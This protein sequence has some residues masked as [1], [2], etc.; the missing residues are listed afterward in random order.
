MSPES[1]IQHMADLESTRFETALIEFSAAV[2]EDPDCALEMSMDA[3]KA[4]AQSTALGSLER[5]RR[6]GL[7]FSRVPMTDS[8]SR[9]IARAGTS[10][11]AEIRNAIAAAVPPQYKGLAYGRPASSPT[12]STPVREPAI[13]S[14]AAQE[15]VIGDLPLVLLLGG[16]NEHDGNMRR[17]Q[18]DGFACQRANTVEDFR[19]ALC[20]DV[21]GV[22]VGK[23]W[24][25]AVPNDIHGVV[26]N[27][28]LLFSSFAWLKINTTG[29]AVEN[30]ISACRRS[31][32]REPNAAELQ[33]SGSS[34]VTAD[35]LA[36]IRE[37]ADAMQN[38]SRGR[39]CP[40]D[41]HSADARLILGCAHRYV[42]NRS[43]I[44]RTP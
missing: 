9:D 40:D 24:W 12:A 35:D 19:N 1:T 28:L 3:C 37:C 26:L 21:C 38:A 20:D 18:S 30:F 39:L 34:E 33:T 25:A 43:T 42:T 23:S 27:E 2:A 29:S 13:D 14:L 10:F 15:P 31:R 8:L 7:I 44:N 11:P 22:V 5:R 6:V 16:A 4:L 41:I 17:L 32:L 36:V